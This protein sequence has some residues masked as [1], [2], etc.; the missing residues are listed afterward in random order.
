MRIRGHVM[1]HQIVIYRPVSRKCNLKTKSLMLTYNIF[2]MISNDFVTCNICDRTF[3]TA[4]GLN[5]HKNKHKKAATTHHEA[6]P[7]PANEDEELLN[8]IQGLSAE[9]DD[10]RAKI[11]D[12][13]AANKE[14][15]NV[16]IKELE[17]A[18][19]NLED[20]IKL[21]KLT[22][23]S[24][25]LRNI[26][27]TNE[28][29][30]LQSRVDKLK[31]EVRSLYT[32]LVEIEPDTNPTISGVICGVKRVLGSANNTSCIICQENRACLAVIP[33]GHLILCKSCPAIERECPIC[34]TSIDRL[35]TIYQ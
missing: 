10:M 3:T 28:K 19:A 9:T 6:P 34:R 32:L 25:Q 2:E 35:L 7:Q 22:I 26:K 12:L 15:V 11:E 18:K 27:L 1:R 20:T 16:K 31:A 21:D 23:G 17:G 14:L 24:L 29:N 30:V 13:T 5:I 8:I 33:C 4:R